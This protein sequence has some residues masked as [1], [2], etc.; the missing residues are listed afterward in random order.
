M[1]AFGCLCYMTNITPGKTKFDTRVISCIFLD[2][3]FN[4]K[5]YKLYDPQ[6]NVTYVSRDVKFFE[7]IFP[8]TANQRPNEPD[9]G[10]GSVT[11]HFPFDGIVPLPHCTPGGPDFSPG[12]ISTPG[13]V[14]SSS[15]VMPHQTNSV[16]TALQPL[17]RTARTPRP[18]VTLRDYVCNN[19]VASNTTY[20]IHNYVD[21]SCCSSSQQHYALQVLDDTEPTCYTKAF[22]DKRWNDAMADE[23]KALQTNNTWEVTD[24]P[25]GKNPV[26]SK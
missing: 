5:G 26:S 20:P 22:K 17:R 9:N 14:P 25:H 2:Y 24:L 4:Q 18:N 6:E 16:S 21:Y 8:Y 19:V 11:L 10:K 23:L 15:S 12:A 13:I 7:D 1:R 3:A